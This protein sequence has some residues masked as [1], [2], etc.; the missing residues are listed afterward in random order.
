M[1]F[2]PARDF[3]RLG[4]TAD[5]ADIKPH[6]LSQALL[7][8]RPACHLEANS[9]PTAKGMSVVRRSMA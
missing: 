8:I 2:T 9:S 6:V 5:I 7:Q 4:E 1:A 3:H